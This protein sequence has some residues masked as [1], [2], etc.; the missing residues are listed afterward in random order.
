MTTYQGYHST[1][2]ND[3]DHNEVGVWGEKTYPEV[4]AIIKV[5]GNDSEDQ[6]VEVAYYGGVS[7]KLP[8]DS[9]AEVTMISTGNDTTLKVALLSPPKDKYRRWK[10]NTGGLQHPND[11]EHAIEFN[12]TRA[13]VTKDAFAVGPKG[14]FEVKDGVVY[15]RGKLVVEQEIIANKQVK[16]PEV[17]QGTEQIAALTNPAEQ[18]KKTTEKA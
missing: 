4:G 10:E 6:E 12:N 14:T 11:P 7:F 1:I 3:Q 2:P 8:K 17:V 9:N 15:V 16:T 18:D 13:H 5:R